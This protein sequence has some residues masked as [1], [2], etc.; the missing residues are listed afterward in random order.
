LLDSAAT[1]NVLQGSRDVADRIML[2]ATP[3]AREFLAP[4]IEAVR[5][6]HQI[7]FDYHPYTRT[8]PTRNVEIEPY[9]L[10]IFRQIWYV[11][12]RNTADS[13]VKTYALDR[14]SNLRVLTSTF[15]PPPGETDPV[16]FFRDSFGIM[17]NRAEPRLVRL[18]VDERQAKYMRA[19][20]LHHSQLEE[21]CNG[22]SIFT[23]RLRLTS[24]FVAEILSHGPAVT[25]L[26]PR[27]LKTMV[28]ESLTA[29]MANYTTPAAQPD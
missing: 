23:Y 24:D 19:L 22:Y 7:T 5:D 3:S 20:P 18:R 9:F 15:A 29:S 17:V 2:E 26:S 27:E 4:C 1:S 21:V 25:V 10:R 12:G 8:N 28:I 14:M 11:T 16:E 13:K 6:N